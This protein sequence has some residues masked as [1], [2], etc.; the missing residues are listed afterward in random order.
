MLNYAMVMAAGF[1][2]RMQ[3]LTFRTPKPM[4]EVCGK[5]IIDYVLNALEEA[6]VKMVVVNTHYKPEIIEE[7]LQKRG[8]HPR[9]TIS[10]EETILETGGGV[11]KAL[12]YFGDNPFFVVN[13]DTIWR[14]DSGDVPAL[15][16]LYEAWDDKTMDALLLL[17]DVNHAV[18]YDGKG[19]FCLEPHG[20]LSRPADAK[21]LPYVFTGVQILH[22]RFLKGAPEGPFSLSELYRRAWQ[23]EDETLFRIK[24]L[25]HTG[26][27][28]HIGTPEGVGLAEGVLWKK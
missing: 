10:R 22:P 4:I 20:M 7:H 18:G 25:A 12:P 19:D 26:D 3:P 8:P 14:D 2:K 27:W 23:K 17:K 24:G 1:G 5:P 28:L 6:G 16:R 15:Q 11:V 13:S 9:V 21:T